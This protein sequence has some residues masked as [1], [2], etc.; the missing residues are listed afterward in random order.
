[1]QNNSKKIISLIA[2]ICISF[3]LFGEEEASIPN[4][5]YLTHHEQYPLYKQVSKKKLSEGE[6]IH[7]NRISR[8]FSIKMQNPIVLEYDKKVNNSSG[9]IETTAHLY[10]NSGRHLWSKENID[11]NDQVY[12]NSSNI[13]LLI[14]YDNGYKATWF[15]QSGTRINCI[16]FEYPGLYFT[17]SSLKN[18]TNWMI[19]KDFDK[20]YEGQIIKNDLLSL[21]F[22]D[23]FGN[24]LNTINMKY[25]EFGYDH[26]ISKSGDYLFVSCM[27]VDNGEYEY[28]T[29]LLRPDGTIIREFENE[30]ISS[31]FFSEDESIYI[32]HSTYNKVIDI[33]SAKIITSYRGH[34]PCK[35][36]NKEHSVLV[37]G[38]YDDVRIIDYSTNKLLF[39][40]NFSEGNINTEVKFVDI[41]GDAK[42]VKAISNGYL[43]TFMRRGNNN[44]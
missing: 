2:L 12:L 15:N 21:I 1:M 34:G 13:A 10:D 43:Y 9:L 17:V 42:T 30:F 31:G 28:M 7:F 41:S 8:E 39:H 40:K 32:C 26:S 16:E 38:E 6:L 35:P 36:A 33:S 20:S 29:Y 11:R 24:Q 44:E 4:W 25:P 19:K 22:T 23:K 18:D 5:T 14:N 27:G 37:S 3:S